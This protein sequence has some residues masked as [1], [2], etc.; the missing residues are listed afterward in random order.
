[1][2]LRASGHGALLGNLAALKGDIVFIRTI[3]NVL[4]D[5]LKRAVCYFKDVLG[6]L[7]VEVQERVFEALSALSSGPAGDEILADIRQMVESDLS[8]RL[9]RSYAEATPAAKTETLCRVLNRP[10]RVCAMVP[11]EGEPGGGP[12]WVEDPEGS[13]SL[14][15]VEAAQVDMD[16][17]EQRDIWQSS[18]YFNPADIVCGLRD[19]RGKPF[20]LAGYRD[21]EAWF[22]STK[23]F[24]DRQV[25][26]LELPGLWNGG[27]AFWNTVFLEVP[28]AT[29]HPVKSV[30]DL[31][32]PRHRTGE[33]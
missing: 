1:M 29:L 9:P 18:G 32:D 19:F 3:D 12:F 23:S 20:N 15:I 26:V 30:M 14:Q 10:L 11:H 7:L 33:N 28:K 25:R 2:L 8:I 31:L 21:P 16:S 17:P 13:E 27:M 22:V 6:G 24:G 5:R 4:P